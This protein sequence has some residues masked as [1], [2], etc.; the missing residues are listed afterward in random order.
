MAPAQG[1]DALQA[2]TAAPLLRPGPVGVQFS[3]FCAQRSSLLRRSP[4][5]KTPLDRQ[6]SRRFT[7][8]PASNPA[9]DK[10][11]EDLRGKSKVELE[12]A[13]SQDLAKYDR[14]F[15]LRVAEI[16]S[17]A[18]EEGRAEL[19]AM[20][21]SV[22]NIVETLSK[23]AQEEMKRSRSTLQDFL[24]S[25]AEGDGSFVLPLSDESVARLRQRVA[26]RRADLDE[27]LVLTLMAW[28]QKASKDAM[29]DMIEI[30]Q[31]VLQAVISVSLA[32]DESDA[33]AALLS[34]EAAFLDHVLRADERQWDE[35]LRE[36]LT[37]KAPRCSPDAFFMA[38]EKKFE[39]TVLNLPAGSASQQA[40]AEYLRE[41]EVRARKITGVKAPDAIL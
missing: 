23:V 10:L 34:P 13:V 5:A 38:V 18:D 41:A 2:F 7:A 19:A 15:F 39:A 17:Q 14:A 30:L 4:W 20:S 32:G 35:L 31:R 12:N 29:Q 28:I 25:A 3:G 21:S 9:L 40:M 1:S 22:L 37:G 36:G 8:Q 33:R 27:A 6:Q 16:A 11:I 26:S 24:A